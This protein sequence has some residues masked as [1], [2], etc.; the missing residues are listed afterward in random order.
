MTLCPCADIIRLGV[1]PIKKIRE[2]I[3]KRSI[4][5]KNS[6]AEAGFKLFCEKGYHGTNT[7]EIAK[8]AHV[9]TGALYS[10]FRD[11]RDIYIAAF[12][13]YI[14]SFSNVL[15]ER[16]DD[17]QQPF[18]L[19]DFIERWISIYTEVYATSNRALAQLR[20]VMM[21]DEKI[22]YYFCDF[23]SQYVSGIV[24]ILNRNNIFIDNLSEKVY[25]SC[26]LVDALCREKS[27]SPHNNLNY[28][29]LQ[30]Q[31]KKAILHLLIA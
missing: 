15:L 26:I 11:K 30:M 2:P 14:N 1:R 10:Y 25:A 13:Q 4:D 19:P 7:I 31:I 9:S 3:Q 20:M 24:E 23:E 29:I 5:K 17:F 16:L 18:N 28:T 12:E 22:N 6:I 8:Q 27:S 21:E